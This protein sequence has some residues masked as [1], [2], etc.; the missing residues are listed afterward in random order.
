MIKISDVNAG[1]VIG[2]YEARGGVSIAKSAI[3]DKDYYGVR[4]WIETL[5][6]TSDL[7]SIFGEPSV[8]AAYS[9]PVYRY[10]ATSREKILEIAAFIRAGLYDKTRRDELDA[11][12][13]FCKSKDTQGKHRAREALAA[14]RL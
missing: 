1:R 6:V 10:E 9:R 2:A 3:V 12:L 7:H 14:T 5:T 13:A 8:R 4:L 11:L